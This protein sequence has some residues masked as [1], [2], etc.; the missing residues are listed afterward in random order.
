MQNGKILIIDDDS[1]ILQVVGMV[2]RKHGFEAVIFSSPPSNFV[3]EVTRLNPIVII[4]DVQIGGYD[5]RELGKQIK[6][7]K[8]LTHIPVILFS[9]NN[10]FKHDITAYLCDDFIEKPFAVDFFIEK[11]RYYAQNE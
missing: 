10:H 8:K 2:L 9:A 4:L 11:I 7:V 5:G 6:E 1:D 3:E